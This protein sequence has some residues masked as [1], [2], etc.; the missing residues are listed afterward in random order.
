MAGKEFRVGRNKNYLVL[1]LKV[2]TIGGRYLTPID[3]NASG[4]FGR[5]IY[6]ESEAFSEKQD[7]YFRADIRVSYRKEYRKSTL[8]VALDLQNV[9]NNKNIFA[10]TYNARTNSIATE[11]QQGFFH[12][13]FIRYTF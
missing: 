12:V 10:Q 2:T 4:S 5:P 11:Y 8:E 7:P 6:V 1:N 3:L 9:T 13:P